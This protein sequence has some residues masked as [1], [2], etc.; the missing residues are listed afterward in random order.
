M[1]SMKIVLFTLIAGAL[2]L[3]QDKDTKQS[4]DASKPASKPASKAAPSKAAPSADPAA[5]VI[6]KGAT[7]VE[8]NLYRYTDADGRTWFYRRLPFGVSKYEEKPQQPAL[9]EQP[10]LVVRD[11]GDSIEFQRNTPFGIAKWVTK[12]ADLTEEQKAAVAAEEAKHAAASHE[13]DKTAP[14]DKSKDKQEKK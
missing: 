10:A 5:S 9:A 7:Q 6:P 8:P 2:L 3:A 14:A 12:K 13:T 11:L 1:K 4:K